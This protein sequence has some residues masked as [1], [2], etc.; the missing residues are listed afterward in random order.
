MVVTVSIA[1]APAATALPAVADPGFTDL[2]ETPAHRP[3]VEAMRQMGIVEGAECAPGKFCPAEPLERWVMAVWLVRILDG[4]E[5]R[6]SSPRFAD[7][8]PGQ[9]W[10]PYVERLAALGVTL[11]CSASPARYCPDDSV[12]RGEMATFLT[13]AFGL[14]TAQP[15]GFT[16]TEDHYHTTSIDS[17]AGAG[18]TIGCATNP[19]RYCPDHSVTRGQMATFLIRAI[20]ATG[21]LGRPIWGAG[22]AVAGPWINTWDREAV[23]AASRGEFHWT[24]PDAKFTGSVHT[25]DPGSTS[26]EY[27]QSVVSR[28]N[29]YR[30]MAGLD[31]VTERSEYSSLAQ[32][33]ALITAANGQLSHYPPSDW[34]C[35]TAEGRLA[36]RKSNLSRGLSGI[37]AVDS[38]IDSKG[39][40]RWVLFPKLLEVGTG[41]FPSRSANALYVV[42]DRNNPTPAVREPRGFVA[43]PPAGYVPERSIWGRWS[44]DLPDADFADATV[45]VIDDQ[46]VLPVRIVDREGF[47]LGGIVWDFVDRVGG[48]SYGPGS[49]GLESTYGFGAEDGDKCYT[50]TISGV[51]IGGAVQSPYRYQTCAITLTPDN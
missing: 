37:K 19:A 21:S 24:E 12:T 47:L 41:D 27:R 5:P 49:G 33:A 11:G 40:R 42:G 23:V 36:A 43:W 10:A 9:W 20:A 15:F 3:T 38:Y 25:C 35:V 44:F 6:S 18:I 4:E 1:L 22:Q 45:T 32:H 2:D 50:I 46:G 7:V 39:H 31:T 51:T 29:W 13:R 28:V 48:F 17:L 30:R 14:P 34:E 8:D 16:D 26:P